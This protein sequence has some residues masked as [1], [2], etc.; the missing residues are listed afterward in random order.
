MLSET[1]IRIKGMKVL[2]R[3][4]GKVE[5]ERFISLLLREPFDYTKWQKQLFDDINVTELSMKAMEHRRSYKSQK[6]KK[7]KEKR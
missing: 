6:R 4:M 7:A 5:A 1:E 2:T 3:G